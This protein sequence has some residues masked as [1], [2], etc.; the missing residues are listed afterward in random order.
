MWQ[1]APCCC[2]WGVIWDSIAHE[3]ECIVDR[4]FR[5]S[6]TGTCSHLAQA[7]VADLQKLF[8]KAKPKYYP[9]RQRYT[10]PLQP[11]QKKPTALEPSKK[12]SE[13]NLSAGAVLIFKDL[14]PQVALQ[15]TAKYAWDTAGICYESALPNVYSDFHMLSRWAT[16]LCSS[17][18]I[19]APWSCMRSYTPSHI[20]STQDTGE[21]YRAGIEHRCS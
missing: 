2:V 16:G 12:L 6:P 21:C 5:L 19:S 18:S 14:G 9:S 7:S 10:L 8:Y 17:G 4:S 13:Y 1:V 3:Q 15:P 20:S 11:G